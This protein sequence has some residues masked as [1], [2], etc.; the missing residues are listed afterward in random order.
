MTESQHR[1]AAVESVLST[2]GPMCPQAL[3]T[4][5]IAVLGMPVRYTT[6]YAILR[7]PHN[8]FDRHPDEPDFWRVI[9][10]DCRAAEPHNQQ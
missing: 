4:Y 5:L 1:I 8:Q 6:V 10:D 7:N 2:H 9:P 3:V